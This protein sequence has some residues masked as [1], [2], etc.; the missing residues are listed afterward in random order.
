VGD[1]AAEQALAPSLVDDA[2]AV[3][4]PAGPHAPRSERAVAG[5]LGLLA[6]VAGEN[7]AAA[8]M[9]RWV[10]APKVAWDR[11][12]S[13]VDPQARHTRKCRPHRGEGDRGQLTND[14]RNDMPRS[15]LRP[16]ARSAPGCVQGPQIRSQGPDRRAYWAA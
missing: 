7:L 2:L 16:L 5:T 9:G 12:T 13:T 14:S 8:A 1:P 6:L 4:R 3:R 11:V 15:S 10:V